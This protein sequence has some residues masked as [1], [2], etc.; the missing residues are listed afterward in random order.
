MV[1][2]SVRI[3]I[4]VSCSPLS[5]GGGGRLCCDSLVLM[6]ANTLP[7][8]TR[9]QQLNSKIELQALPNPINSTQLSFGSLTAAQR[10][11][12]SRLA[13]GVAV[14]SEQANEGARRDPPLSCPVPLHFQFHLPDVLPLHS[15]SLLPLPSFRQSLQDFSLQRL[16]AHLSPTY[17]SK[18]T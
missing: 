3:K 15:P 12:R 17:T 7:P 5:L 2:C 6:G 4:A 9:M 14:A 8:N 18:S 1:V 16:Q 13:V 11:A 10:L